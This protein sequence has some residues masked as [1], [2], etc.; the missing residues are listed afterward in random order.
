MKQKR[1]LVLGSSGFIGHA[2]CKKLHTM[3]A[4]LTCVD[5]SNRK[6]FGKFLELDITDKDAVRSAFSNK[7]EFDYV[8]N[9][10]GYIDH[11]AF[12]AGGRSVI[13]AHFVGVMNVLESVHIPSIQRFVQVGTSDEYG[14]LE[15]PQREDLRERPISPY[16]SA[17]LGLTHL[18]EMLSRTENFPTTI[19]RLFL[20]YGPGQGEQRLV[21]QVIKAC[22]EAR[23]FPASLGEQLRDFAYI[24]DIVDGFIAAALSPDAVGQTINLASGKAVKIR[25]L[26]ESIVKII[27]SGTPNFGEIPYRKKENMALYA[28]VNKAQK[29]LKWTPQV[30]L[31]EGL[32][33]TIESTFS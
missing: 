2:L 22:K 29:L 27:G 4:E 33:R 11:K 17:K 24:D 14:D 12:F 8:F 21:P 6:S 31:E 30:S 10:S 19:L 3:G 9:L 23:S 16:S 7:P 28:D 15:A 32:K 5:I 13:D 25:T 18:L 26:I 1:V 20:V